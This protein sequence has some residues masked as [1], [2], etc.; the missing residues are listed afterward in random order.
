MQHALDKGAYSTC[1]N[2]SWAELKGTHAVAG[3]LPMS[4]AGLRAGNG[5]YKPRGAHALP[6]GHAYELTGA[7]ALVGE[8]SLPSYF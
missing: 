8:N 5:A 1:L 3:R 6:R 7:C 4:Q 2:R